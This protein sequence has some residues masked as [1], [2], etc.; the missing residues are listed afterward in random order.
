MPEQYTE[1]MGAV[2]RSIAH[3]AGKKR[4][5]G[6]E[7]YKIDYE[8]EGEILRLYQAGKGCVLDEVLLRCINFVVAFLSSE[9]SQTN[10]V[11]SKN[12]GGFVPHLKRDILCC[13]NCGM[14]VVMLCFCLCRS[15][16]EDLKTEGTEDLTF[17]WQ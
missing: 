4:E 11:G 8:K 7:D 12:D 6:A 2:C 9:Y 16:L 15:W 13:F 5:D 3:V 10:G 14:D 1:A 17:C